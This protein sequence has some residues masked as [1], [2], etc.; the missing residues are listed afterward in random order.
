[1][2]DLV[3]LIRNKLLE[4]STITAYIGQR[5]YM[6]D[7]PSGNTIND[8]P[9]TTLYSTDGNTDSLTN[10][11]FPDLYIH[12]WTKGDAKITQANQ[13]AR[14]VLKTIDRKSYETNDPCVFQIWKSAGTGVTEDETQVYHK[15]LIF[16][17]VMIGYGGD[18]GW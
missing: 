3:K 17:V 16:D 6:A 11:Y 14:E 9:Q 18:A 8:Y 10:D 4:N 7:K 13:I 12:I 1:M 2:I 15:I 5:I